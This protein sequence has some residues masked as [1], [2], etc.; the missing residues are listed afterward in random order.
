MYI[1]PSYRMSL[2]V[3][4][5]R[6][7]WGQRSHDVSFT[8]RLMRPIELVWLSAGLKA[9]NPVLIYTITVPEVCVRRDKPACSRE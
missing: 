1:R 6:V 8:K 5:P 4:F 2:V 7:L 9:L 3:N